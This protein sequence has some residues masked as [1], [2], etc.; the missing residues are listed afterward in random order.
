[1]ARV[2]NISQNVLHQLIDQLGAGILNEFPKLAQWL[3]GENLPTINQLAAFAKAVN[4]PFGY[5]FLHSLPQREYPIPH[6]RTMAS[7]SFAPS[8]ELKES[9][10]I[11]QERQQWARDLLLELGA[12]KIP[13]GAKYTVNSPIEKT[14]QELR[15]ILGLQGVW[16]EELPRWGDAFRTLVQKAEEAGVFVVV[17]G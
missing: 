15:A 8:A 11:V 5:F 2:E 6:Y 7:G 10:Q 4:V 16:A 3:K 13:F 9:I 14:A 17:N 12:K 1:M